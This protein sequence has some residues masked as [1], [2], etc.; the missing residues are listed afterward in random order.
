MATTNK[1]WLTNLILTI[2]LGTLLLGGCSS[3]DSSQSSSSSDN[4]TPV[5]SI[6][7][8]T[9]S[10]EMFDNLPR[11]EGMAKVKLMVNGSPIII[12]LNG[13]EAPITA[14][15][16]VDLVQRGVYNGLVFHRVVKSPQPFVAQGGDPLGNGTG[17][18]TD[19]ETGKKRSIPLEIKL[20]GDD[21][22][23][24][25]KG[26]GQQSGI[27]SPDVVLKHSRGAVAMARSQA[28]DS[29]SSQFYIALAQLDFLDG[30]YAVF[31]QVLEGM[32]AV[33]GIDQGDIIVSAE[34]IEGIENLKK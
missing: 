25:S 11:L 3:G 9:S 34:V 33:D 7:E 29:A 17:G 2:F 13:I 21:E 20:T 14:G 18:F 31:G 30:D 5:Q 23:T 32:D 27:M 15:N 4:L 19:P 24:Y 28:P 8:K 16:F 1:F 22:P 12:E 10:K 26:L 6:V